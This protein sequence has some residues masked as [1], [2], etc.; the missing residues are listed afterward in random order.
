MLN[1]KYKSQPEGR[2]FPPA[3]CKRAYDGEITFNHMFPGA[4]KGTLVWTVS[5]MCFPIESRLK[6]AISNAALLK[7]LC[8]QYIFKE[9][10]FQVALVRNSHIILPLNIQIFSIFAPTD[11]IL[12]QSSYTYVMHW[13]LF[14]GKSIF[15]TSL[16]ATHKKSNNSKY[17]KMNLD[18]F[19][20]LG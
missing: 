2:D 3:S 11:K 4:T 16:T 12:K 10:A 19:F 7:L 6:V 18:S 13:C 14:S 17:C 5:V 1:M 9:N 20:P 15:L 8:R